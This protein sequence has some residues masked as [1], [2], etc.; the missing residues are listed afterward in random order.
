MKTLRT[1]GPVIEDSYTEGEDANGDGTSEEGDTV[2]ADIENAKS[3]SARDFLTGGDANNKLWGNGGDDVLT[4]L[5]GADTLSGGAGGDFLY[6]HDGL[7]DKT[8]SCGTGVDRADLDGSPA[9]PVTLDCETVI[10]Y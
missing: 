8:T 9:D 4:G 10:R 3:G 1:Q 2:R 6:L 5:L 7:L